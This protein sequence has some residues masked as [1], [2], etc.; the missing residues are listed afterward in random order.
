MFGTYGLSLTFYSKIVNM[1]KKKTLPNTS[2]TLVSQEIGQLDKLTESWRRKQ[3]ITLVTLPK[4]KNKL[5]T[6]LLLL[7]GKYSKYTCSFDV[8]EP[9]LVT[10]IS[11]PTEDTFIFRGAQAYGVV[12]TLLVSRK[13]I[14]RGNSVKF[15]VYHANMLSNIIYI[16]IKSYSPGNLCNYF[17]LGITK[18]RGIFRKLINGKI[19]NWN[20]S[21]AQY[22]GVK[23]S[24]IMEMRIS[25]DHIEW[26]QNNKR[27]IN[28]DISEYISKISYHFVLNLFGFRNENLKM[29]LSVFD[30]IN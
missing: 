14:K 18:Y 9:Q 30:T 2:K 26:I 23:R 4:T 1:S 15:R 12:K 17:M 24:D 20:L 28:S 11:N 5:P 16:G 29:T 13:P 3:D 25:K 8:L 19:E 7:I 27:I 10:K 22:Q 21:N 6:E